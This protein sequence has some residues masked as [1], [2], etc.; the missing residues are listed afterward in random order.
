V[1]D[2]RA[3]QRARLEPFGGPVVNAEAGVDALETTLKADGQAIEL[4]DRVAA[5]R[6]LSARSYHRTLKV[7]R[8]IADL[9]ESDAVQRVHVAEA[10]AYRGSA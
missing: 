7:A 9:A 1:V 10:L 6:R 8:T 5:E 3:R 2:A 4:V